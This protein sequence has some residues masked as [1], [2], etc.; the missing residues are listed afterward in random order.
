MAQEAPAAASTTRASEPSRRQRDLLEELRGGTGGL[1]ADRVA[2]RAVETSPS[3]RSSQAAVDQARAGAQSA[4]VAFFPQLDLSARY[5]RLSPITP[6]SL[7][8]GSSISPDQI[9]AAQSLI[10]NVM[11]PSARALFQGTL[12]GQVAAANTSFTFPVILN[13]YAFKASLSWPV[14]DLF[15]TILP[16]YNATRDIVEAAEARERS[17]RQAIALNAREA[18]YNYARARASALVA[19]MAVAQAEAHRSDVASFVAAGTAAQVELMRIDAQLAAA[20]VGKARADGGVATAAAALRMLL[21]VDAS[22]A[23]DFQISE[24]LLADMP[25]PQVSEQGLYER[26]LERR[27]EVQALERMISARG[28]LVSARRNAAIPHLV[29][30]GNV[31]IAN[32]NQRFIPQSEEFN[33]T[34]DVSAILSWSPN[35]IATASA[36]SATASADLAA[37]NADLATLEDSVRVEVTQSFVG[38]QAAHQALAAARLGVT[39]AEESYRIRMERFHA[40]SATTTEIVDADSELNRARLDLINAAVDLRIADARMKRAIGENVEE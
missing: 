31:D 39:A 27:P 21:H 8:L 33:T 32:P 11:D 13:N 16:S 14:S 1:T 22:E 25:A 5:T 19:E 26:A 28:S 15:L 29:L 4:L 6:P 3:L 36:N 40:G 2:A 20:R 37:A 10:N 34:W 7:G 12:D 17:T 38:Y 30:S 35:S 9:A 24:D 23:Q 18:F